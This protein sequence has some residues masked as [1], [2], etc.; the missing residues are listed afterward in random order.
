MNVSNTPIDHMSKNDQ[1]KLA[2]SCVFQVNI[3]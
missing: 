1:E 2:T 3:T